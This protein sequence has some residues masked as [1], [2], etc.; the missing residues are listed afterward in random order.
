MASPHKEQRNQQV[1]R[2][3]VLYLGVERDNFINAHLE[4]LPTQHRSEFIRQALYSAILNAP[5][6]LRLPE[7]G[8]PIHAEPELPP[9]SLPN[10]GRHLSEDALIAAILKRP[11]NDRRDR[12]LCQFTQSDLLILV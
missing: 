4:Q 9:V 11:S 8:Q 12:L 6:Q 3:V 1:R 7:L 5:R 2:C 10:N